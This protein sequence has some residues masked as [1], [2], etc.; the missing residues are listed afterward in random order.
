[1]AREIFTMSDFI[2]NIYFYKGLKYF[3]NSLRILQS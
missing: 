3:I 2:F 1:M